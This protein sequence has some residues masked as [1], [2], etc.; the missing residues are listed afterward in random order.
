MARRVKRTEREEVVGFLG[1]GLDGKDEHKRVTTGENFFL[2]GGSEETH[3]RMID[4]A[5]HVN[6]ELR[7]RGKTLAEADADEVVDLFREASEKHSP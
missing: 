1:V 5:T 3:E 6:G 2:I 4:T 7:K